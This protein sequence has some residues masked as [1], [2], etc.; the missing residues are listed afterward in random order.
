MPKHAQ[1]RAWVGG[2]LMAARYICGGSA[3]RK[4][5]ILAD[6]HVRLQI[7]EPLH[8]GWRKPPA[9]LPVVVMTAATATSASNAQ[10][11]L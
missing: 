5:P 7:A 6:R 9:L 3:A 2:P 8:S 11:L 1:Q 10:E 4:F